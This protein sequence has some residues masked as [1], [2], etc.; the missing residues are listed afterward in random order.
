MNKQVEKFR[1]ILDN[2]IATEEQHLKTVLTHNNPVKV[3]SSMKYD[4]LNI[5][6]YDILLGNNLE[7]AKQKLSDSG[8]LYD[9]INT[10]Y[11]SGK[12][13][14]IGIDDLSSI[15]ISDNKE[16]Y[17]ELNIRKRYNLGEEKGGWFGLLKA[18]FEIAASDWTGLEDTIRYL[19]SIEG[20]YDELF[21]DI[22]NYFLIY[23]CFIEKDEDGLERALNILEQPQFRKVRQ[24]R[25]TIEKYISLITTAL[26]KLAWMHGMEVRIESEYV[27]KKLLPFEPLEEYTIP[28][29]F[30]RDFYREQGIDWRYDPIHPELQDWDN[31]P[32]NPDRKKGG[33]F[34]TLFG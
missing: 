21:H 29:K 9:L 5:G 28:Y 12:E 2:Y 11:N 32:E 1:L 3:L 17:H 6:R 22:D 30:L 27:P 13:Y 7:A 31:D 15:L 24:R 10:K 25:I 19:E 18:M 16:L 23:K 14:W 33:F 20:S 4:P 26:A 8:M 34:K